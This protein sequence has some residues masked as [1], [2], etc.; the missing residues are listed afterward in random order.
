MDKCYGD[1]DTVDE[2]KILRMGERKKEK[3]EG[4]GDRDWAKNGIWIEIN[5]I[6]KA[7]FFP[8]LI[9]SIRFQKANKQTI[10]T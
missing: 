1:I 10:R 2:T 5:E 6:T 8:H 7:A 3:M 9:E 4:E